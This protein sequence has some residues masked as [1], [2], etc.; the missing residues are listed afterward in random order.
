MKS[1]LRNL[2]SYTS[3]IIVVTRIKPDNS[4]PDRAFST[5][6]RKLKV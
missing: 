4:L 5:K 2:Q 1:S 6:K 3:K